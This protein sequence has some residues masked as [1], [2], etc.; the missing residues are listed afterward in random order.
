M[1]TEL[2][3][4]ILD[5]TELLFEHRNAAFNNADYNFKRQR[6][7]EEYL[8][9]ILK[10][11]GIDD[12]EMGVQLIKTKLVTSEDFKKSAKSMKNIWAK[13]TWDIIATGSIQW[14]RGHRG[15]GG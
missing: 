9:N 5:A 1:C 7:V 10:R 3:E 12:T 15:I 8:W 14:P 11:I 13:I 6:K 2:T 4:R